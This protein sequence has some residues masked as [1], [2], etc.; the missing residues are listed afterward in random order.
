MVRTAINLFSVRELDESMQTVIDRVEDACY[1]GVQISGG[2]RDAT[3]DETAAM[4]SA[5][6]LEPTPAH[7]G[8]DRLEDDLETVVEEYRDS[9]GVSDVVLPYLDESH[10]E[11]AAAVDETA[12][13]LS[14]LATDL[15]AHGLDL[16]YH[17]HEHEFVDLGGESAFERL[18]EQTDDVAIE[19]D[20]G[21]AL[22]GGVDPAAFVREHADRIELLHM[23]DIDADGES[24][25]EIGEGDVDMAACAAAG[26][27]AGVEWFI[28]EHDRPADPAATIDAGGAFLNDL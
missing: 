10:F 17:N 19:L 9:L 21:W 27:D 20:V 28:Y 16:H 6:G 1:D 7:I 12:A 26:R 18:I 3:A 13:R 8:I 11:S 4:L 25:R 15:A 24:F 2:F 22:V 14:K 23:K 5:A